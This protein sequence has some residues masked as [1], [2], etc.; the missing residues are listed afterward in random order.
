MKK[1]LLLALASASTLSCASEHS[2]AFSVDTTRFDYAETSRSGSLLDTETNDFGEIVGFSLRYEPRMSGF[3]FGMS[4]A[5]GDTDYIGGTTSNP[6]YGSHL[7]TTNNRLVDYT[8]G[9]QFTSLID[10]DN[11][12]PLRLGIGY[13]GWLRQLGSTTTVYGYDELYEWGYYNIGI[14]WHTRFSPTFSMGLDADYRKAFN[15][16]MYE[17]WH[18]YTYRLKNVYGYKIGIPLEMVLN[19][20]WSA[21]FLYNYEYWNIGASDNVGGYYEPDSETKNQTLSVGLKYWF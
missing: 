9:Y 1:L 4:Y 19:T 10:R 13:R 5:E 18:G 14:G 20:S 17:N 2:F 15:A 16:E 21:F 12:V 7:T 8:A 6:T 3:Y 11:K